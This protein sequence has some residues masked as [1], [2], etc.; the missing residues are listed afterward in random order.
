MECSDFKDMALLKSQ[1]A[2]L[3]SLAAT[4]QPQAAPQEPVAYITENTLANLLDETW[5]AQ[6]NLPAHAW[7]TNNP[8]SRAIVPLYASPQ[9]PTDA[10]AKALEEAAK[11]CDQIARPE[12]KRHP[13]KGY[14]VDDG[15]GCADAIRAAITGK[16]KP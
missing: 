8:P 13:T 16:D 15:V 9:E 11:I 14:Y 3:Q 12:G 10:R 1:V 4:P 6:R 2:R 5:K 7:T